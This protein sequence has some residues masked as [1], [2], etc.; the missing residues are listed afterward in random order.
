MTAKE[1]PAPR[2]A[3]TVLICRDTPDG[4]EV[5]M[6]VRHHKIDF[7]SGALVFPGGKVCG[8]DHADTVPGL[9]DGGGD[10]DPD[11][12]PYYV[13]ALRESFEEC[14]VL[15]A[16][17][18][19]T[20]AMVTGERVKELDQFRE[21]LNNEEL[22]IGDFLETHGLRLACDKIEHFAYWVTPEMMPKRFDTHFFIARAPED[23]IAV[24]DGSESV[25]SVWISPQKV[26]DEAAEG[27]WTV[28]FPTRCNLQ[29]LAESKTVAEA[30]EKARASEVVKVLPWIEKRDDGAVLC[31]PTEAGYP[32]SE[33]KVPEGGFR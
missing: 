17:S 31:I 12:F 5:F 6:V 13:A 15:L 16:T 32:V 11:F 27:K 8:H 7:A 20:G 10:I 33:E 4:M 24:H 2:P 26:L 21:P 29:K 19:D 18:S 30:M 28:I 1:A 9:S 22:A 25:D 23:H 14:G 3:A